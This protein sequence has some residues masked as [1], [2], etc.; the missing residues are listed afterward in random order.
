MNVTKCDCCGKIVGNDEAFKIDVTYLKPKNNKTERV[1][2][3]EICGT[4]KDNVLVV[5]GLK[6][7]VVE[8][9]TV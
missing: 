7:E 4:C 6:N 5:L 2:R 3:L 8:D 1:C 9:E